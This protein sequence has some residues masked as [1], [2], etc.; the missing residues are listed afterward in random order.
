MRENRI[1]ISDR[2]LMQGPVNLMCERLT[3]GPLTKDL[4][5]LTDEEDEILTLDQTPLAEPLDVTLGA[6]DVSGGPAALPEV[7]RCVSEPTRQ[8]LI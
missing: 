7:S 8:H 3:V 1:S 4:L 5:P 6:V 2:H